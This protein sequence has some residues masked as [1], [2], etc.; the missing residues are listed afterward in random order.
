MVL[1][2]LLKSFGNVVHSMGG[3]VKMLKPESR[4]SQ[5]ILENHCM[6]CNIEPMTSWKKFFFYRTQLVNT[7]NS[8]ARSS[9]F[10]QHR[11]T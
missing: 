7:I 1:I 2:S 6:N 3:K 10:L 9:N 8:L 5:H 11:M 4:L